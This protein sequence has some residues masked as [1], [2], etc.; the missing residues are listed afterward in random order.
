MRSWKMWWLV[1]PLASP[2]NLSISYEWRPEMKVATVRLSW[3]TSVSPD[4]T[5]QRLKV[6]HVAGEVIVEE[7]LDANVDS[8]LFDVP[9][10]SNIICLLVATDGTN[11]SEPATL[12]EYIPDLSP[13]LAPTGLW[14]EIVDVYDVPD[15]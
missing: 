3:L 12:T 8:Y 2:T 4:V 9:E 10:K 6:S 1:D 5:A 14:L 11:D 7:T 15:A 13:P